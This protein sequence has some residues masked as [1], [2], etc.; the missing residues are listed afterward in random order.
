MSFADRA[1]T[2]SGL[3]LELAVE[4]VV[5][6]DGRPHLSILASL[7]SIKASEFRPES[8]AR[9]GCARRRNSYCTHCRAPADVK[10]S[11]SGMSWPAAR[12]RRERVVCSPRTSGSRP[13]VGLVQHPLRRRA[14]PHRAH[15][16][17][18]PR[19][20]LLAAHQWVSV[21]AVAQLRRL[22]RDP[23]RTLARHQKHR[24]NSS[25]SGD[26][27]A[28][29]RV[30]PPRDR[31]DRMKPGGREDERRRS[32]PRCTDADCP[33]ASSMP[34]GL[35][36]SSSSMASRR[37]RAAEREAVRGGV[38][39]AH[40]PLRVAPSPAGR[41]AWHEQSPPGPRRLDLG[42]ER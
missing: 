15:A 24:S 34:G 21:E 17:V 28:G 1:T 40:R 29:P 7:M 35:E 26:R 25:V 27:P 9:G 32:W 10:P 41:S 30:P 3:C 12:L 11:A 22:L 23:G 14:C 18:R 36:S 5:H 8:C 19:E 13:E 38:R 16:R 20:L 2:P 39:P 37:T 4:G 6:P 33:S 42:V 31:T